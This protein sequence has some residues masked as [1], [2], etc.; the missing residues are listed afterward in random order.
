MRSQYTNSLNN[1]HEYK[2]TGKV[3]NQLDMDRVEKIEKENAELK[4]TLKKIL[5]RLDTIESRFAKEAAPAAVE[6][7]DS[8]VDLFGSDE[9]DDEENERLK[10]ERAA[11][12]NERLKAKQAIKGVVAAKSNIIF[13]VKPWDDETDLAEMEKLVRSVQMDGL[14]WGTAKLVPVGYGIKKIQITCVVEDEKVSTQDLEDTITGF[15]DFVQSIDV[16]AFNKI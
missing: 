14:L 13:D 12:Y 7:E 15:E 4:T 5:D 2:A 1:Y 8:D 9:E 3:A 16:V 11:A 6:A 10:A